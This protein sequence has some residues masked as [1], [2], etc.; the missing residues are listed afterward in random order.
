VPNVLLEPTWKPRAPETKQ[1]EFATRRDSKKVSSAI[2]FDGFNVLRTSPEVVV[3]NFNVS[4]LR[5]A[6]LKAAKLA[7]PVVH[8]GE[9]PECK[10]RN[11]A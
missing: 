11:G 10:S 7:E 8:S 4:A 9:S 2:V 1:Q 6:E 5:V 3:N